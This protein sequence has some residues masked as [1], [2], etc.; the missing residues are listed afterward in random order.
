MFF[1]FS[2]NWAI[3]LSSEAGHQDG[4]S[5]RQQKLLSLNWCANESHLDV[6][7]DD[8]EFVPPRSQALETAHFPT[9]EPRVCRTFVGRFI[10]NSYPRHNFRRCRRFS[11][12]AEAEFPWKRQVELLLQGRRNFREI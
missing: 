1:A 9:G 2:K 8:D 5:Q 11:A 6:A 10:N 12:V 4:I 3:C 7:Y